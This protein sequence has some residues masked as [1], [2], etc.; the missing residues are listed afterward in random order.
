LIESWTTGQA[1]ILQVKWT[2]LVGEPQVN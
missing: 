2:R 1:E